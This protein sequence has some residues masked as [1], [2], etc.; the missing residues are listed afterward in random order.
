MNKFNKA[1]FC[2]FQHHSLVVNSKISFS[3]LQVLFL[4]VG[5]GVHLK[6]IFPFFLVFLR[7]VETQQVCFFKRMQFAELKF[8]F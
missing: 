3:I 7:P 4:R 8:A 5:R 6:S 1:C 2:L